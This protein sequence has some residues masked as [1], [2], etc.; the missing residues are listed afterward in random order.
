MPAN[1]SSRMS[2][3]RLI[4]I[5]VLLVL[6]AAGI[7]HSARSLRYAVDGRRMSEYQIVRINIDTDAIQRAADGTLT[8]I[9]SVPEEP[10]KPAPAAVEPANKPGPAVVQPLKKP[11]LVQKAVT[12][13][14]PAKKPTPKPLPKKPVVKKPAP[15]KPAPKPVAPAPARPRACPT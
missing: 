6:F 11:A 8:D 10:A 7:V 2:G 15:K 14:A 13:K 4:V 5:P 12:K 1:R 9:Y 3:S